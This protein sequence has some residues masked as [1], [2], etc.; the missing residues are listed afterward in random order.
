[1]RHWTRMSAPD[2][3][4]D[5]WSDTSCIPY[6]ISSVKIILPFGPAILRECQASA[7][8]SSCPFLRQ[9]LLTQAIPALYTPWTN[10]CLCERTKG[11]LRRLPQATARTPSFG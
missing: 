2:C 4:L 10:A 11:A 1:M 5:V 7:D 8:S 9:E 6:E 3:G